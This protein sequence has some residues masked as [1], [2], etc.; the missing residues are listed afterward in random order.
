MD[1]G[2]LREG[3]EPLRVSRNGRRYF[4]QA[5]KDAVVAQCLVPGASLAAV[6][7]AHGF[8]A[9]LVRRW[10]KERQT[11]SS[12]SAKLLPVAIESHRAGNTLV[13][14]AGSAACGIIELRVGKAELC[15][16]GAV[17]RETLSVVL[18]TLSRLR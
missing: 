3:I 11:Q 8:N 9:N 17:E 2:S 1:R 12:P 5:H 15:V 18:D 16:R 4:S 10:V 13:P 7:L 6:A 14:A